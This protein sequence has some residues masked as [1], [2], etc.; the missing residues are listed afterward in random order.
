MKIYVKL[1]AF[2]YHFYFF[3]YLLIFFSLL[4]DGH[5]HDILLLLKNMNVNV[6][7]LLVVFTFVFTFVLTRKSYISKSHPDNQ[8]QKC[9]L[10][11]V[12]FLNISHICN[13]AIRI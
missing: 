8:N 4:I 6:S 13:S 1:K 5:F 12:Q 10:S 9:I 7:F 3:F 2:Y 11:V